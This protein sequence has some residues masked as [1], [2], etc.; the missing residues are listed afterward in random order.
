MYDPIH[1]VWEIELLVELFVKD[2]EENRHNDD[3]SKG[4]GKLAL[5]GVATMGARPGSSANLP[6]TGLAVDQ[7]LHDMRPPF[8]STSR[9]EAP[10]PLAR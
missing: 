9:L 8:G 1:R 3:D 10:R 6:V 4:T 2:Y 5:V 7:L